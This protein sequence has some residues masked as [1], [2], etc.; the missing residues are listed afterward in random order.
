MLTF[1]GIGC[2]LI[3]F[4]FHRI[5]ADFFDNGKSPSQVKGANSVKP[6]S[7]LAHYSSSD[8]EDDDDN[9]SQAK[10]PD[11]PTTKL[12][13]SSSSLPPGN[14]KLG[15]YNDSG[16]NFLPLVQLAESYSLSGSNRIYLSHVSWPQGYK[17]FLMLSSAEPKIFPAH[18]C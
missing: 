5:P 13:S 7:I 18:K 14:I 9:D 8:D 6:K 12:K 2:S 1:D 3:L 17:T 10:E 11:K 4:I 15:F 16:V